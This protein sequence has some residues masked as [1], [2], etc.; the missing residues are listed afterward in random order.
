V[1]GVKA[2]QKSQPDSQKIDHEN[3]LAEKLKELR[4][5]KAQMKADLAQKE[6]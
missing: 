5:K 1:A 6:Q 2:Q 4:D 3:H